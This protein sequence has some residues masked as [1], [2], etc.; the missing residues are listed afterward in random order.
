MISG[1][2]HIRQI[3]NISLTTS[4]LGKLM[5][6]NV[7]GELAIGSDSMEGMALL[8]VRDENACE[9]MELGVGSASL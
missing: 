4:S 7:A 3:F 8:T 6:V 9:T 1:E 2:S 5:A